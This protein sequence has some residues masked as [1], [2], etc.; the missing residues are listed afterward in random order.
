[1]VFLQRHQISVVVLV[2][3]YDLQNNVNTVG[4]A[5]AANFTWTAAA[6]PNVTGETTSLK[7]GSII[8]DVLVNNSGVNQV[9]TYTVTP[10]S[11]T[12]S[13]LGNSF[14]ITVNVNPKAIFTAGPD[15]AVMC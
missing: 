2:V 8:D 7:S 14:T 12:G 13:C 1:L 15:L 6:H 10:T 5:L 4:N 3:G 9:V 11:Q